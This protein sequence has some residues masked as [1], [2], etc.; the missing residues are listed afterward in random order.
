MLNAV[1]RPGAAAGL[2]LVAILGGSSLGVLLPGTA[3]GLGSAADPLIALL[4]AALFFGLPGRAPGAR[5]AAPR[6]ALVAVGINFLLVPLLAVALASLLPDAGVRLGVL[7]Y[8]LAPCTDWFLGFTRL[9]DGDTATGAALI[10]VQL[11]LQL[12]LYPLWLGWFAGEGV[13]SVAA[14]PALWS[15]FVLPCGIGLGARFLLRRAL[16]APR[17]AACRAVVDRAVPWIIAGVIFVIFA[18]NVRVVLGAPTSLF[19]VLGV[20]F[21]FFCV[22]F[23]LD[24]GVARA[25]GLTRPER[26][27]LTM[28]T[29]ARNAPLML[30]LTT[31]ALPDA[32]LVHAAIVLGMLVEFPHLAAL[33]A[34]L[35]P[36]HRG[37]RGLRGRGWSAR[38]RGGRLRGG[39]RRGGRRRGGERLGVL[40]PGE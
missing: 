40:A 9:A 19:G 20:V 7:L 6:T 34:L 33:A 26:V 31:I 37:A 30:A 36:A 39:R 3:A 29:S 23:A 1:T 4:V 24:H 18:G 35:G 38:G 10:P 17:A 16:S 22:I 21:L 5:R 12:A 15:G 32:P 27:L 28:T 14:I 2:F 8:C 25:F 13:A 11:T